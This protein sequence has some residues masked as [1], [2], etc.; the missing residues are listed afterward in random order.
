MPT[1]TRQNNEIER[2]TREEGEIT[3][4]DPA[5]NMNTEKS[6]SSLSKKQTKRRR[7]DSSSS[8]SEE[9][10]T[11]LNGFFDSMHSGLFYIF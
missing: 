3:S 6:S 11:G 2:L 10:D 1:V 9:S 4:E 5:T 8:S 7:V